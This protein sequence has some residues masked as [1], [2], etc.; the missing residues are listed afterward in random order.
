MWPFKKQPKVGVLSNVAHARWLRA[1]SPH[2]EV[3]FLMLGED[4][5]EA[6]ALVGDD[7]REDCATIHAAAIAELIQGIVDGLTDGPAAAGKVDEA[8][9]ALALAQAAAAGN[10]SPQAPEVASGAPR[11]RRP[12]TMGGVTQRREERI[13]A[14]QR[15]RDAPR[16]LLGFRPDS[17]RDR[18]PGETAGPD[19]EA[20]T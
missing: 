16:R 11:A 1:G 8:D 15:D 3:E 17:I 9:Y 18:G 10:P 4:E 5:Q 7:Y 13:L 14:D 12:A 6:L 2:P 19:S 20:A